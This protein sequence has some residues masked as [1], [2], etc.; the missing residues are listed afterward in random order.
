MKEITIDAK[1]KNLDTVLGMVRD[2]MEEEGCSIRLQMQVE[3]AVEEIYVNIA[4]YAYE[5][6]TGKAT[7]RAEIKKDPKTLEV[8]FIDSGIPFDP[9]AKEDP[10]VNLKAQD[11][12][13][14]GLGIYMVKQSMDDVRYE[15]KEDRNILI[16]IKNL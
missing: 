5:G 8:T 2:L 10:D 3:V 6:K 16:L 14:G 12:S 9:L 11:R 4:H 13:I 1:V 15:R 7:V